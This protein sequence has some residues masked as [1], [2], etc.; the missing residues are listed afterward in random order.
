LP[1]ADE[2]ESDSDEDLPMDLGLCVP[3]CILTG[4][5]KATGGSKVKRSYVLS[6]SSSCSRGSSACSQ[7]RDTSGNKTHRFEKRTGRALP[8]YGTTNDLRRKN[9]AQ[10][11]AWIMQRMPD[12]R[13]V[14]LPTDVT[15]LWTGRPEEKIDLKTH[16]RTGYQRD[17]GIPTSFF[18]TPGN[19]AFAYGT[20]GLVGCSAFTVV[21]TPTPASPNLGFYMAHIW[22]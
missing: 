9:R 16:K 17:Y 5:G 7:I 6:E 13:G 22:E 12:P 19:N 10:L 1:R 11:E 21:K 20:I 15:M 18:E 8:G 14:G 2:P 4:E 3:R